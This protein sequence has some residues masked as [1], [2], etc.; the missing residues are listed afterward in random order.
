M[1]CGTACF[2]KQDFLKWTYKYVPLTLG[3]G[4][5]QENRNKQSSDVAKII[6]LLISSDYTCKTLHSLYSPQTGIH[7]EKTEVMGMITHVRNRQL[8]L[9]FLSLGATWMDS[10]VLFNSIGHESKRAFEFPSIFTWDFIQGWSWPSYLCSYI[11]SVEVTS[12]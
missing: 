7:Q 9:I 4:V 3:F 12:Q 1:S 2:I 11:S 6:C 10:L 8:P 5:L